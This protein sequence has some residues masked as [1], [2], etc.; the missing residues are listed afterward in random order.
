MIGRL[1]LCSLSTIGLVIVTFI[2]LCATLPIELSYE[3]FE[4]GEDNDEIPIPD[5]FDVPVLRWGVITNMS[6]F[7]QPSDPLVVWTSSEFDSDTDD[8]SLVNSVVYWVHRNIEYRSDSETHG[9]REYWQLPAETLYLMTGDCEDIAILTASLLEAL[10]FDTVL[11]VE[12]NHVSLGVHIEGASGNTIEYGGSHYLATDP[13][14]GDLPGHGTPDIILIL[15]S[16]SKQ[17]QV[18]SVVFGIG[19]IIIL[20]YILRLFAC[21]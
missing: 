17:L 15:S 20:M 12:P 9:A 13:T 1:A 4:S 3:N 14:Q 16:D 10:G 5:G 11:V 21:T 7:V 6:R 19:L 18:S 8:L 2:T